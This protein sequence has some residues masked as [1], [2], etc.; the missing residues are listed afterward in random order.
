MRPLSRLAH[1]RRFATSSLAVALG[2]VAAVAL[3]SCGG[4]GNARLLPGNTAKEITANLDQV[5]EL[6]GTGD[7]TAAQ[8]AARQV[9]DQIDA[10]GGV[11]KQLKQALRDGAKRLN[12]VVAA[13]CASTSV[14]TTTDLSTT[15]DTTRPTTTTKKPPKKTPT[16]PTT[17]PTTTSTQTTPTTTPTTPTT[18]PTTG[19][20]GSG[21]PSGG[22][23]A[24]GS[25]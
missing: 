15:T 2:V 9:S 20:G 3:V 23:G 18:T 21:P 24:G 5:V 22:V 17:T 6:S 13:N 7:C 4:G 11:D 10:L 14:S 1:M 25:G 16:T 19:G 8:D 12:Q